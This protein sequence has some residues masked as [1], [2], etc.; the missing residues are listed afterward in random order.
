MLEI[1]NKVVLSLLELQFTT[2]RKWFEMVLFNKVATTFMFSISFQTILN[3]LSPNV[4][5]VFSLVFFL[6]SLMS[7]VPLFLVGCHLS[8]RQSSQRPL[9][10]YIMLFFS[11]CSFPFFL[12]CVCHV[13][14]LFLI[15]CCFPAQVLAC[16]GLV[17]RCVIVAT[18]VYSF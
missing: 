4:F 2:H 10:I 5:F 1:L 9:S 11:L 15:A 12:S 14:P 16:F 3:F 6:F 17:M 7:F 13:Y 8:V 18:M